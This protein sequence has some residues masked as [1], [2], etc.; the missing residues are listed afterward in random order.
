V[1]QIDIENYSVFKFKTGLE[2]I[3]FQ[4]VLW[5]NS[6]YSQCDSGSYRWHLSYTSQDSYK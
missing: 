1:S 5:S 4:N 6:V 2:V 3:M